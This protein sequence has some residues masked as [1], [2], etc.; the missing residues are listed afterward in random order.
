[1]KSLI[2]DNQVWVAGSALVDI[3]IAVTMTILVRHLIT[4]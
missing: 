1:M 3:I 2:I 4:K